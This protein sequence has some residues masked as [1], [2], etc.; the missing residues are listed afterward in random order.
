[1]T[2]LASISGRR[3]HERKGQ[4]RYSSIH[5]RLMTCRKIQ[6]EISISVID[7]L[8]IYLQVVNTCIDDQADRSALD[9]RS[10]SSTR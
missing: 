1:M 6:L 8:T 9:K 7:G 10:K 2:F 3:L 5:F 4:S